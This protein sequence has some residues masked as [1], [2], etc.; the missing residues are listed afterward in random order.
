MDQSGYDVI[1]TIELSGFD[2]DG[3]PEIRLMKNGKMHV[4]FEFM[5]PSWAE[6][7]TAFD[8][9]DREMAEAIGVKVIWEDREFFLIPS[10]QADTAERIAAFVAG[11]PKTA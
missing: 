7:E 5:P 11:Y 9:F 8:R 4:V 6:D 2:A 10:P 1:Q 3:E